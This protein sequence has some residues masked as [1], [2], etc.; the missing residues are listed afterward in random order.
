MTQPTRYIRQASFVG[1]SPYKDAS[2]G[3]NLDI[4]FNAVKTTTDAIE[5]RLILIQRDDGALVNQ[6]VT[7]DSLS[8]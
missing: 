7:F 1:S 3:V 5:D 2:V 6:L 4:E 8:T